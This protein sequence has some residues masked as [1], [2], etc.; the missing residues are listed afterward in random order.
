MKDWYEGILSWINPHDYLGRSRAT[1]NVT[2]VFFFRRS[3]L[4]AVIQHPFVS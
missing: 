3:R 1:T 2:S 4:A